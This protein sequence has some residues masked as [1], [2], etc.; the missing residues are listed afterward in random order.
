MM[1]QFPDILPEINRLNVL[2]YFENNDLESIGSAILK[3]KPTTEDQVSELISKIENPTQQTLI[4]SLA[5]GDESWNKKGC[6]RLLGKFVDTRQKLRSGSLL[7]AQIKAAEKRNDHDLLIT[8]LNKKQKMAERTE[9]QKMAIL[10][11]K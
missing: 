6:L 4:T 10:S 11:E 8:L 3:F 1:L 2:E 5:I 9:K 7:E